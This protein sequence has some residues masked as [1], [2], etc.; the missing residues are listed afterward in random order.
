MKIKVPVA[1][2]WHKRGKLEYFTMYQLHKHFP[3]IDFEFHIVL[4]QPH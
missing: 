3:E 2:L 1:R 4:D